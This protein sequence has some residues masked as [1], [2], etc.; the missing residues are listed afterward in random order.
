MLDDALDGAVLARAVAAFHHN[1]QP[2]TAPNQI[3]LKL[4]QLNMQRVELLLVVL[5]GNMLSL[6]ACHRLTLMQ[7]F[8]RWCPR[9][10]ASG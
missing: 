4:H 7:K 3:A 5:V 2:L 1:R 8:L 10:P 9:K 6:L